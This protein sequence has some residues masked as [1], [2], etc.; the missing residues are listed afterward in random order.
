MP[1]QRKRKSRR[2][3]GGERA[4]ARLAPDAGRWEVLVETQDAAEFRTRI[5]RLQ[6]SDPRIDWSSTR[7]D[8]F[9]GRLTHP[10][11]HRLSVFVPAAG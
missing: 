3:T 1:G 4:A 9:C 7:I 8:T 11:T 10:T 6:A 5:R 2:R